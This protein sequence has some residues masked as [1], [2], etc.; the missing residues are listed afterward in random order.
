MEKKGLNRKLRIAI[1]I[2]ILVLI[3][4][5]IF[6][7]IAWKDKRKA[8]NNEQ[9]ENDYILD[10][11][12]EISRYEIQQ[13]EEEFKNEIN[14]K[15]TIHYTM[16]ESSNDSI[17][18]EYAYI[19]P[20]YTKIKLSYDIKKNTDYKNL[21]E[22]EKEEF[23]SQIMNKQMDLTIKEEQGGYPYIETSQ[24]KK[25]VPQRTNDSD[26]GRGIDSNTGICTWYDTFPLT[27]KAKEECFELCFLDE[28]GKE[29]KIKLSKQI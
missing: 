3:E 27:T 13:Q 7:Y 1:I 11:F 18:L 24:K 25:I 9:I 15:D 28:I 21:S 23:M 29:I 8:I 20:K 6:S 26:G 16:I 4:I 12:D 2:I 5:S 17:I 10:R 22:N 14:D 19:T